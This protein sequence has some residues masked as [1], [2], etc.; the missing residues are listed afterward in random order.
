MSQLPSDLT[1]RVGQDYTLKQLFCLAWRQCRRHFWPATGYFLLASLMFWIPIMLPF[2]CLGVPILAVAYPLAGIHL[3]TGY[4]WSVVCTFDNRRMRAGDLFYGFRTRYGPLALLGLLEMVAA[5]LPTVLFVTAGIIILVQSGGS[6]GAGTLSSIGSGVAWIAGLAFLVLIPFAAHAFFF[7]SPLFIFTGREVTWRNC[8]RDNWRVMRH[9]TK[10]F[11]AVFLLPL[12]LLLALGLIW[13]AAIVLVS[14]SVAANSSLVVLAML[15]ILAVSSLFYV[16]YAFLMAALFRAA[17]GYTLDAPIERE[18]V[19][20]IRDAAT[21][22][23][24]SP[25]G[26]SLST[27]LRDTE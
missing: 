12:G 26:D 2:G 7:M 17:N 21:L 22:S 24:H 19:I 20:E 23:N 25:E 4:Q 14:V 5:G 1:F 8:L 18:P 16:F 27:E 3:A 15:V 11:L 10:A 13:T 9:R 6:L